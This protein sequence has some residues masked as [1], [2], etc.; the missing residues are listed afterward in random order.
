MTT[1]AYTARDAAG[2]PLSGTLPAENMGQ[3]IQTLRSQ[4]KYPVSVRP[5]EEPTVAAPTAS[6]GGIRVRR[7]DVIHF[8]TQLAIMLET[9][10]VLSDAVDCIARQTDRPAVRELIADLSRQL[11]QGSSLSDAMARHPRSFP[12][13]YVALIRASERSGLMARLLQRATTY[14][15]E[16]QDTRRRVKGAMTYP[17]IMFGFAITTTLFLLTFVLPRFTVIYAQ[18]AAALPLPTQ[19]LIGASGFLVNHWLILLA[20][21][22]AFSVAGAIFLRTEAGR[23]ALNYLQI[24]LPLLGGLY[25]GLQ[26]ARGLRTVGTMA[27]AGICLMDCVATAEEL[28]DNV[29]FRQLWRRI[30]AQIEAGKQLSEPL[31]DNPLVPRSVAQMIL[32]GEKSGKL[33]HVME[34]VAAYAEQELK[35]RIAALTRYIEPAMILVMGL[36]IGG[37]ALA[38]LLPVFTISRVM[39]AL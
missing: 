13:L 33:P 12:T 31:F 34:Q 30:A 38:L 22:A 11:Q 27:A 16:E 25:R 28:S 21:T 26:L 17:L 23:R 2:Q 3:V 10:V 8:S 24:H 37:I 32:S 5:V 36:I 1:F 6:R 18:K 4:G 29:Y 39:T 14:L 20:S 7:A 9:G 15:R 19:I 35:D